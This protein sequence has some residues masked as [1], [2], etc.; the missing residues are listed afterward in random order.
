MANVLCI[1][2]NKIATVAL[3]ENFFL[4]LAQHDSRIVI[5]FLPLLKITNKELEKCD[6]LYMIRPNNTFFGRIAGIAR[7]RGITVVI[8]LDDDLLHLPNGYADMFWRK[9]GL[10]MSAQ[11]SDI[12]VSSSPYI[13]NYY[14]SVFSIKRSVVI[15]T[16]VPKEDIKEHLDGK[17]D[18]IKIVYAA[19][20]AHKTMFDHFI[21]P[22]LK[23]LDEKYG[24]KISL[25]FMGVHPDLDI[26]EYKMPI[27]FIGSLPLNEYRA[28]IE[29]E[30]FDLGLAPLITSEFTKCKY[31]NKFIE[32]AMFGIVGIYSDTEPYTL[33]VKDGGNGI[34]VEDEPDNWFT[35]ISVAIDT[36]KLISICRS[37]AY[38]MLRERFDL[39]TIINKFVADIPELTE[40]HSE[41]EFKGC[42][43]YMYKTLYIFSR[44]GDWFYKTQFYFNRGGIAEVYRGIKRH[45]SVAVT[46][47]S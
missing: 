44:L 26:R 31:F 47:R 24:N 35:A 30:N 5:K 16:A 8:F 29:Q 15:D 11:N 7:K 3:T 38:K 28:R 21:K 36:D 23:K 43:L 12:I 42:K 22:I 34:L 17:N 45:I 4:R 37:N 13:C 32:Y 2:E 10:M 9:K 14:G 1:Y 19:G 27:K 6:L 46:V 39:K 40:R 25:T 33:V 41:K 20:L 18:R